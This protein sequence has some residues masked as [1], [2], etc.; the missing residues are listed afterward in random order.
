MKLV[1]RLLFGLAVH[2]N[3]AT[4]GSRAANGSGLRRL[5]SLLPGSGGLSPRIAALTAA[6]LLGLA[7]TRAVDF[8]VTTAQ[9][10]QNA[11]TLA[12]ANG[13]DD[14]IY[15]APHTNY[16]TGNF[17]FNSPENR[18]LVVQGE[19]GSTNTLITI[20]VQKTYLTHI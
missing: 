17:N 5:L 14:N 16:Y 15:L 9:E 4:P 20:T 10:L 6:T 12:A 3:P 2:S 8:H 18:S 1:N 13:A 7:P 11:L 19:P